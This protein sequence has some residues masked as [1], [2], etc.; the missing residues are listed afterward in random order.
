MRNRAALSRAGVV[1]DRSQSEAVADPR[2]HVCLQGLRSLEAAARAISFLP[3]QPARS[4]LQGRHRSRIR[5][6]GLDFEELRDYLPGDDVRAID[7]KVTARAGSPYV[8]VYTEER[9]R[10]TLIVVDQ[11]MSMFYGTVHNT[12]AVTAAECAAIVAHRV[13]KQGDRVGGVVFGDADIDE[14]RPGRGRAAVTRFLTSLEAANHRLTAD[15]PK[16][17]PMPF[18]EVLA[19]VARLATRD[20]L[21]ILISDFDACDDETERR[22]GAIALHND[23]VLGLVGDPSADRMPE[24]GEVTASDG[25]KQTLL[26]FQSEDVRA[27]LA[28]VTGSRRGQVAE[29]QQ[30]MRLSVLPLTTAEDTLAQV[31][32]LLGGRAR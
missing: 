28:Q 4:A 10:P 19:S 24:T 17:T 7:W 27:G 12:K 8:R 16:V 25:Q 5:G 23:V 30:R 13:A 11:R 18:N 32:R 2:I 31:V 14:L 20:H 21:V 9:D 3:K 26:D 15:A 22:L 1:P 6:R 29:W